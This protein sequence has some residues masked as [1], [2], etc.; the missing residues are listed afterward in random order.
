[1]LN[2]DQRTP[3]KIVKVNI[4]KKERKL[5]NHVD[6]EN[7]SCLMHLLI[8]SMAIAMVVVSNP[9]EKINNSNDYD[10]A[11]IMHH[12][13]KISVSATREKNS[14]NII[15][16]LPKMPSSSMC[17]VFSRS[18]KELKK[19]SFLD[20]FIFIYTRCCKNAYC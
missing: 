11:Y 8:F 17:E 6:L 3:T 18:S 2:T 14:D 20:V 5:L 7:I 4:S 1:M 13:T 15:V 9:I 16:K 10:N 19:N 12:I